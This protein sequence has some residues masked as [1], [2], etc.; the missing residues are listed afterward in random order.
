MPSAYKDRTLFY[1]LLSLKKIKH[2]WGGCELLSIAMNTI[3][4]AVEALIQMM[5]NE[6]VIYS[7]DIEQNGSVKNIEGKMELLNQLYH[8][9]DLIVESGCI[10]TYIRCMQQEKVMTVSS[11]LLNVKNPEIRGCMLNQLCKIYRIID[12][13]MNEDNSI[14]CLCCH[15]PT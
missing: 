11:V 10:V 1:I 8:S 7:H 12:T 6:I 4:A 3:I 9:K 5:H 2:C 14:H 13:L 15:K